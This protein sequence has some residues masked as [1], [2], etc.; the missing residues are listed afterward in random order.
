MNRAGFSAEARAVPVA[1]PPDDFGTVLVKIS[2][3]VLFSIKRHWM[4]ATSTHEGRGMMMRR[5]I[6]RQR[7]CCFEKPHELLV[8]VF[9]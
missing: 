3:L 9:P 7:Q 5:V 4:F 8:Q 1:T 6:E 2:F